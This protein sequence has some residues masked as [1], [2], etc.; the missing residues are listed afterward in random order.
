LTETVTVE[1]DVALK[2]PIVFVAVN[3][4][5]V[6]TVGNTLTEVAPGANTAGLT[7]SEIDIAV[8]PLTAQLKVAFCPAL[9]AGALVANELIVGGFT[10]VQVEYLAVGTEG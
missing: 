10:I 5:M 6:V 8:A 9:I 1:V 2:L 7:P 3:V 4:Y